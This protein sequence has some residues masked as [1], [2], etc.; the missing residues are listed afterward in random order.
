VQTEGEK[1]GVLKFRRIACWY[2]RELPGASEFR[3]RVNTLTSAADMRAAVE[4]FGSH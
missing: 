3:A 1:I 2:L 4:N